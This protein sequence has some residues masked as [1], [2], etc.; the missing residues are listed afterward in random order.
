[1]S[2]GVIVGGGVVIVGGL[3][4]A[5][6]LWGSDKRKSKEEARLRGIE[7]FRDARI[8]WDQ[9]QLVE[10]AESVRLQKLR[11]TRANLVS[12]Q[13]LI[14]SDLHTKE[15]DQLLTLVDGNPLGNGGINFAAAEV[16]WPTVEA[17]IHER[18]SP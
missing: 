9:A 4:T 6:S 15:M 11:E 13:Q 2:A 7:T 3:I 17:Q 8:A 10:V 18:L 1:M 5:L 16:I 14:G 12:L